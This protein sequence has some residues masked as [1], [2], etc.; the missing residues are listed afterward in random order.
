[1][2]KKSKSAVSF[3]DSLVHSKTCWTG[4]PLQGFKNQHSA[5]YSISSSTINFQLDCQVH[6]SS[7]A[8]YLT[9]ITSQFLFT[10][11]SL[12]IKLLILFLTADCVFDIKHTLK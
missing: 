2:A 1:M 9:T 7:T 10:Y 4:V 12:K 8:K 3:L 11:M 6:H 5:E